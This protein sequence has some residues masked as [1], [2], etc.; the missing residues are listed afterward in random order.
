VFENEDAPDMLVKQQLRL[1]AMQLTGADDACSQHA[2]AN[3]ASAHLDSS[4]VADTAATDCRTAAS[5]CQSD[6]CC[7]GPLL[8]P[9]D[10]PLA[11]MSSLCKAHAYE[12][13]DH[14][15]AEA[16][17]TEQYPGILHQLLE[18]RQ[19]ANDVGGQ[20]ALQ[21]QALATAPLRGHEQVVLKFL[22]LWIGLVLCRSD[23]LYR[24]AAASVV[25]I[26]F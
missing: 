3:L 24:S 6:G 14:P 5:P 10:N 22:K 2:G 21:L 8:G 12:M 20:P 25:K 11:L 7:T 1:H 23:F 9:P 19:P 17:T 18:R 13:G 15:P 26:S 4:S 16:V